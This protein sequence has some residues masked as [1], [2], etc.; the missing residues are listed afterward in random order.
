[1]TSGMTERERLAANLEL[2]GILADPSRGPLADFL[3]PKASE[4]API[5]VPEPPAMTWRRVLK[6]A[7]SRAVQVCQ[8]RTVRTRQLPTRSAVSSN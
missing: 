8:F 5:M 7:W 6:T 1:L 4:A 3:Y 2:L